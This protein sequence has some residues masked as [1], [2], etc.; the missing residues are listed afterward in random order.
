M[1]KLSA[2]AATGA[3][4]AAVASATACSDPNT[5]NQTKVTRPESIPFEGKHQAGVATPQQAHLAVVAFTVPTGLDS[6]ALRK[7]TSSVFQKWTELGRRLSVGDTSIDS[8]LISAD[9]S[10]SRF[11][12]TVGVGA[13]FVELVGGR[14]PDAMVDLPPF[15][16]EHLEP[17]LSGGDVLVQLCAEDPLYLAG[18]IRAVRAAASG[19]LE[20]KWQSNG[21]IGAAAASTG[22]SPRNLFGQI[23]GTNN[24]SINQEG[25][26]GPV[27]ISDAEPAWA[28]GGTYMVLRHFGIKLSEWEDTPLEVQEAALGRHKRSGAPI[29]RLTETDPVDLTARGA[30]GELVIPVNSHIRLSTPT[31]GA[32]EEMLRRSYSFTS[33]Q[34]GAPDE[35]AGLIFISFQRDPRTS[36]IPVQQRLAA[37]DALNRF[38]VPRSSSLFAVLPGAVDGA[39]WLG[40]TLLTG[41]GPNEK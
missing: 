11:T 22:R 13:R 24:I 36:F 15:V 34:V 27:W 12:L 16:D 9:T 18:A 33:G 7:S 4:A 3:A 20:S 19:A 6:D 32:G 2:V 37:T 31:P 35:D 28:R 41:T 26:G 23:D 21:F 39:D 14:R 29:G 10:T 17:E 8:S 5:T 1:F 25:D 40:R 38:L 30:D